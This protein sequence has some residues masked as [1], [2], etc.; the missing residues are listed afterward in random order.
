MADSAHIDELRKRYHDNPRRFFAP[1]ANEYR[2]AGF[3]DR[4]ALLCEKHLVEQTDNLNGWVVYGQ[5]LFEAGRLEEAR[6]PFLRAL[7]LDPENLIALR[8]LG[9]VARLAGDVPTAKSWYEKVLEFDQRNDEV[10][11]LLNEMGVGARADDSPT[12]RPASTVPLISVAS[13]VSVSGGAG[14]EVARVDADAPK[15]PAA[16]PGKTKVIEA[17]RRATLFDVSFDFSETADP[18]PAAPLPAAPLMGAEAAEYGFADIAPPAAATPPVEVAPPVEAA[19][20]AEAESPWRHTPSQEPP[21]E[22][23]T[24]PRPSP[25]PRMTRAD[26]ASLPLLADYG[27]DDDESVSAPAPVRAPRVPQKTPTFVT[28][29]MATLYLQ[30]GFRDKAIEVYRQLVAQSP[31]TPALRERLAELEQAPSDLPELEAPTMEV[32]APHQASADMPEFEAPSTEVPEPEPA[33]ANAVLQEIS[34]DGVGLA[35]PRPSNSRTP[36]ATPVVAPFATPAATPALAPIVATAAEGVA[37]MAA[38]DAVPGPT[39]REFFAAF[40]SR[41]LAPAP[42]TAVAWPLDALFGAATDVRDLHAAEVLSGVATFSGPTGGTGL[43]QL[44]AEGSSSPSAPSARRS[45][46][47][48]SQVLNFDQF[49]ASPSAAEES[50]VEPNTTVQMDAVTEPI[51]QPMAGAAP[52]V[53]PVGPSSNADG[54]DLDEFKDWLQGL[55]P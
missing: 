37:T 43:D 30:Q 52:D 53:D 21:I 2:K 18:P 17:P 42:A 31:E 19:R 45:V 48:A 25:R 34:F 26:L 23:P 9:D 5:T 1:L 28:E 39:A 7:A 24:G 51:T 33:P 11:D 10:L 29:T 15:P 38:S 6:Q 3:L 54:D 35:T 55:K 22:P 13:T 44:F 20:H 50:H 27:L 36:F 16:G 12:N 14:V 4:A 40:A 47:R 32:L 41:G 49:F 46:T 8:Q